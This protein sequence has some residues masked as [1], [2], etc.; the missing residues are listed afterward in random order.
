M[1][2]QANTIMVILNALKSRALF[3]LTRCLSSRFHRTDRRPW[4][5]TT[6][7]QSLFLPHF[8]VNHQDRLYLATVVAEVV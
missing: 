2:R 8:R 4:E 6:R 7:K 3:L 1:L 5:N